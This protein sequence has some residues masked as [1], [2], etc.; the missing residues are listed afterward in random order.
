MTL[1]WPKMTRFGSKTLRAP[2]SLDLNPIFFHVFL[3]VPSLKITSIKIY[4]AKTHFGVPDEDV[5]GLQPGHDQ[6]IDVEVKKFQSKARKNVPI[7]LLRKINLGLGGLK[8]AFY[9]RKIP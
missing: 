2:S 4:I 9:G 1:A 5:I 3:S 8:E 7:N 6:V